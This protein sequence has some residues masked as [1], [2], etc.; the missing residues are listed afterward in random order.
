MTHLIVLSGNSLKNKAWGE[1]VVEHYGSR[2]DSVF[3]LQYDHWESGESNINFWRE[4]EKL[5]VHSATLAPDT[6][7]VV[8][9]KS[10][11][12]LLAMLAVAAGAIAP[13]RCVF[14]GIPFDLAA[15][16]MFKDNW[17]A[18][19][20]FVIPAIAFHNEADPTTSHTFTKTTLENHAPQIALI[21][22]Q[23]SDH[24]YGDF[25]TY[26]PY[27]KDSII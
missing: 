25:V 1:A 6:K 15:T 9:A 13:A 18:V 19:D 8:F 7:V 2:F 20:N 26:D 3:M 5:R 27:I 21:T 17:S 23:E 22:T 24:W 14:F 10:A 16:D 12:S 4:V 11:G